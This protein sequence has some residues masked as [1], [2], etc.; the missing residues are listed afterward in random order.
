[1][2]RAPS[3]HG[4]HVDE[5]KPKNR[6]LLS[7]SEPRKWKK[8]LNYQVAKGLPSFWK[9]PT[10]FCPDFATCWMTM[11]SSLGSI[12]PV[13]DES[14]WK[15]HPC[16]LTGQLDVIF[17]LYSYI[18]ILCAEIAPVEPIHLHPFLVPYVHLSPPTPTSSLA[19]S[20]RQVET[21]VECVH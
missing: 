2:R 10:S 15:S 16:N 1:M 18:Y 14:R 6:S 17:H 21:P 20:L 7:G 4:Q 3:W 13:E 5:E 9:T 12:S 11:S 19:P 8:I